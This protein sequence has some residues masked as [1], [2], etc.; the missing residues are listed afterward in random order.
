MNII[1]PEPSKEML[2][3]N[4]WKL[5][6]ITPVYIKRINNC[7]VRVRPSYCESLWECLI[8]NEEILMPNDLIAIGN[9]LKKLEAKND[10]KD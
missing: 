2:E 3:K 1:F 10:E 6:H 7:I 5:W 4:G 8:Q 9:E